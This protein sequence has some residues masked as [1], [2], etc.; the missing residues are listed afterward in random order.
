[1]ATHTSRH[2]SLTV[3]FFPRYVHTML[4]FGLITIAAFATLG[5]RNTL[6]PSNFSN[7]I[8]ALIC[9][10]LFIYAFSRIPRL[11]SYTLWFRILFAIITTLLVT[12]M[13]APFRLARVVLYIVLFMIVSVMNYDCVVADYKAYARSKTK[14]LASLFLG[15]LFSLSL[16]FGADIIYDYTLNEHSLFR[17]LGC[18]FLGIEFAIPLLHLMLDWDKIVSRIRVHNIPLLSSAIHTYGVLKTR[19]VLFLII[20]VCW[21]PALI[22]AAPGSFSYDAPRQYIQAAYNHIDDCQP[23]VSSWI[24]YAIMHIGELIGGSKE[25]G[26]LFFILVQSVIFAAALAF[27]LST[28][29]EL[30]LPHILVLTAL[31]ICTIHP[32]QHMFA[33]NA[34]KNT[35]FAAFFVMWI[36]YLA[37][38]FFSTRNVRTLICASLFAFMNMLYRHDAFYVVLL[39][40]ICSVWALPHKQRLKFVTSQATALIIFA[41]ITGPIFSALGIK[42]GRRVEM[43]GIPE[44]QLAASY[45]EGNL[46]PNQVERIMKY[47][48]NGSVSDYKQNYRPR[49]SDCL[50]PYMNDDNLKNDLPG[51]LSVYFEIGRTHPR[52]YLTAALNNSFG[53]WYTDA[54]VPDSNATP[55]VYFEWDNPT[56]TSLGRIPDRWNLLPPL[57][58]FYRGIGQNGSYKSVPVISML[59]SMGVIVW[60]T[61]WLGIDSLVMKR[62]KVLAIIMPLFFLCLTSFAAP[63][64]LYRFVHPVMLVIPMV[65]G[66]LMRKTD[67]SARRITSIE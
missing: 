7:S 44:Q 63:T 39:T 49:N 17:S 57:S 46:T 28:M 16:H 20:F 4:I 65:I 66:L 1:M 25:I 62:W 48:P 51:F 37:R 15:W 10:L 60:L 33:V 19:V 18:F 11:R 5:F 64:F 53:Y 35:L 42:P 55:Q 38:Y 52:T 29:L 23:A 12:W 43:F 47:L 58:N 41:L 3:Q 2:S 67:S 24:L 34:G 45:I 31:L 13:I 22:T 8:W 30:E 32:V 40:T 59:F 21:I 27:M 6:I 54:I 36:S 56:Y 50:R 26:L 9:F 61:L 14:I